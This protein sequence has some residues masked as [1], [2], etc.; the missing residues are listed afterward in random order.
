MDSDDPLIVPLT[1][2]VGAVDPMRPDYGTDILMVSPKGLD[3]WT[4]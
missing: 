2:P 3:V 1:A 4:Y